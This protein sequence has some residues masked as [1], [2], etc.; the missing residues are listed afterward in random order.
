MFAVDREIPSPNQDDRPPG[1]LS[2]IV[3]HAISLPPEEFGG[4]GVE[5][6]FGNRLDPNQHPYYAGIAHL[7][8]SAHFFVR[9]DGE[10]VQFVDPDKRAWHAG[11][12]C[13]RG[14]DRCNDFSIGIELEGCDTLPFE[15]VQYER[16]AVLIRELG[17]RYPI[18]AVVGHSDIAPGRKTDPGPCFEWGRLRGLLVDCQGLEVG[19]AEA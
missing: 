16:L 6:L 18:T 1:D 14:R 5:A 3:V 17:A 9:R 4:P 8:V 19:P 2:L 11:T 10:V 15:A 12:S 7:R 13:W